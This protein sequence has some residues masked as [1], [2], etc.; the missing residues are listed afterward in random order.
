MK[1]RIGGAVLWAFLVWY[2]WSMY[3]GLAGI[4]V[5]WG[6]VLVLAGV[7]MIAAMNVATRRDAVDNEISPAQ[8][9]GSPGLSE[10]DPALIALGENRSADG[11]RVATL[12]S[13]RP[14]QRAK[15]ECAARGRPPLHRR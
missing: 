15:A 7:A 11:L 9:S 10:A 1:T 4:N 2:G 14:R 6:P 12:A 5:L 3:A 8:R 13:F